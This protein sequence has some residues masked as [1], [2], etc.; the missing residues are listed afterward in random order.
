MNTSVPS[1]G[2]IAVLNTSKIQEVINESNETI[3]DKAIQSGDILLDSKEFPI[4]SFTHECLGYQ[5]NAIGKDLKITLELL[6]PLSQFES[7]LLSIAAKSLVGDN[8]QVVELYNELV[9]RFQ[10]INKEDPNFV[11][12]RNEYQYSIGKDTYDPNPGSNSRDDISRRLNQR[13]EGPKFFKHFGM[14]S[15]F[16]SINRALKNNKQK[17]EESIPKINDLTNRIEKLPFD[18]QYMDSAKVEKSLELKSEKEALISELFDPILKS[19]QDEQDFIQRQIQALQGVSVP[20]VYFFYGVGDNV[21]SWAGPVYAQLLGIEYKYDGEGS[22]RRFVI[23]YTSL[24]TN[25]P[26]AKEKETAVALGA[27]IVGTANFSLDSKINDPICQTIQSFISKALSVPAS[28]VLVLLPNI[29]VAKQEYFDTYLA[30]IKATTLN[31]YPD[32]HSRLLILEDLGMRVTYSDPKNKTPVK[33]VTS[34]LIDEI[35]GQAIRESANLVPGAP[36]ISY[37]DLLKS[38]FPL[39]RELELAETNFNNYVSQEGVDLKDPV[40]REQFLK[41]HQALGGPLLGG[42]VSQLDEEEQEEVIKDFKNI[43]EVISGVQE[44]IIAD[45]IASTPTSQKSEGP[46]GNVYTKFKDNEFLRSITTGSLAVQFSTNYNETASEAITRLEK[47]LR[48]NSDISMQ[49]FDLCIETDIKVRSLLAEVSP[50]IYNSAYIDINY[51]IV[52][53]GERRVISNL[54]YCNKLSN[55]N[56]GY[57]FGRYKS[58]FNDFLLDSEFRNKMSDLINFKI[59]ADGTTNLDYYENLLYSLPDEYVYQNEIRSDRT[60]LLI[61]VFKHNTSNSNVL[62]LNFSI[63]SSYYTL[64]RGKV[65]PSLF[66]VK[67]KYNFRDPTVLNNLKKQ[68]EEAQKLTTYSRRLDTFFESLVADAVNPKNNPHILAKLA[69]E[70][71]ASIQGEPYRQL[72]KEGLIKESILFNMIINN[73]QSTTVGGRTYTVNELLEDQVQ[74]KQMQIILDLNSKPFNGTIKT[75]PFFKISKIAHVMNYP[76]YLLINESNPYDQPAYE[77]KNVVDNDINRALFSGLW[78]LVGF[79]HVISETDISSTFSLVRQPTTSPLP[80]KIVRKQTGV[81]DDFQY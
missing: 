74:T 57:S 13:K 20:D 34:D 65:V 55:A 35:F 44:R 11:N 71:S 6:D 23:K 53:F 38:S 3:I 48:R 75:L 72:S 10:D 47:G 31:M 9:G 15:P 14:A 16:N 12:N 51:P 36:P 69:S 50:I 21:N 76:I 7:H 24:D 30:S 32:Y 46:I 61:P 42:D 79:K 8:K 2:V 1:V 25:L 17:I 62:S 81:R 45:K 63:D 54:F 80:Y 60:K 22:S 33:Q 39:K 70:G 77:R 68:F 67:P 56:V 66:N 59:S 26:N 5:G 29:D 19:L 27:N 58:P 4:L 18:N 49:E 41:I 78:N 73:L 37:E 43:G 64:L 28:N 52:I 40:T